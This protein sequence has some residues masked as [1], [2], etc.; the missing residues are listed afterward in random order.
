MKRNLSKGLIDQNQTIEA[1]KHISKKIEKSALNISFNE[2]LIKTTLEGGV[3]SVITL[4]ILQKALDIF[5]QYAPFDDLVQKVTT[6]T[7]HLNQITQDNKDNTLERIKIA[8]LQSALNTITVTSH[9]NANDFS[10]E[11]AQALVSYF[12]LTV[13]SSTEQIE[14]HPMESCAKQLQETL[15][16]IKP[17]VYLVRTLRKPDTSEESIRKREFY[18][19]SMLYIHHSEAHELYFDPNLGLYNLRNQTDSHQIIF[20]ILCGAKLKF[21]LDVCRFHKVN[22]TK[23]D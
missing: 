19:H 5:S 18:G 14:I 20:Q 13:E 8:S 9:D 3:C 15:I 4:R 2:K 6:F 10:Q 21:H 11:K 16:K 22:K 23:V 17:G 7:A 12:D 1:I